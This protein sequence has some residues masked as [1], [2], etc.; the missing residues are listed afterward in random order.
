MAQVL[1]VSGAYS[2][3]ADACRDG[4]SRCERYGGRVAAARFRLLLGRACEQMR[5]NQAAAE[6]FLAAAEVFRDCGLD[7][8][9]ITARSM[10]AASASSAADNIEATAHAGEVRQILARRGV[11]DADA[12]AFAARDA[13]VLGAG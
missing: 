9:E 10:L 4:I 5:D 11:A 13:C 1:I 7:I 2:A 12:K 6:S 3:A 8:E